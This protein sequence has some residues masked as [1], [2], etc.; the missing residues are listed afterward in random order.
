M[1]TR[2]LTLSV[3][4]KKPRRFSQEK[5]LPLLV[6]VPLL[7]LLCF[8]TVELALPRLAQAGTTP[9]TLPDSSVTGV[10]DTLLP[11]MTPANQLIAAQIS[12]GIA[13]ALQ[14]LQT[15]SSVPSV[16]DT[17]LL[18]SP[19]IVAAIAAASASSTNSDITALEQLLSEEVGAAIDVSVLAT[20][21]ENLRAAIEAINELVIGLSSEELAAAINSPTFMSVLH[22]LK[23]ANEAIDDEAVASA[24][25]TLLG[26]LQLSLE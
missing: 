18:L 3:E 17:T 9:V 13:A 8:S 1:R 7:A 19:E 23:G 16:G 20:S 21:P 14:T 4:E 2:P 26:I 11:T 5:A 6:K 12:Q 25:G 24:R 22:L 10:S 15:D